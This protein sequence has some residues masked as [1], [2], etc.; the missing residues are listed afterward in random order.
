MLP[1]LTGDPDVA[2]VALAGRDPAKSARFTARFGG[3]AVTGYDRL[4]ARDDLDAVYIPLPA[5][6]HAEWVERALEAGL[7]G[8]AIVAQ[9]A[10]VDRIRE[11]A[12]LLPDPEPEVSPR[13]AA[14]MPRTAHSHTEVH[15]TAP[16]A[17]IARSERQCRRGA[18]IA[19]TGG[20]TAPRVLGCAAQPRTTGAGRQRHRDSDGSRAV[21]R[22]DDCQN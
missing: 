20:T 16:S 9:A 17:I 8:Q 1:A 7:E 12:V 10:L 21:R 11:R 18:D 22:L 19:R 14:P 5:A 4:L 13:S 3:E 15:S 6:L 2:V